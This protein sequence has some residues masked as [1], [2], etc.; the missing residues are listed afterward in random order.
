MKKFTLI[1]LFLCFSASLL[2]QDI[3]ITK[4]NER[5]EAKV[6]KEYEAVILYS[7]FNTSTDSTYL[8]QKAKINTITYE[9]GKVFSYNDIKPAASNISG[10]NNTSTKPEKRF[11]NVIRLKPFV[12]I[13]SAFLGIFEIDLQ[14]V[15]YVGRKVGIPFE[16]D[17]FTGQNDMGGGF[18]LLTGVEAVPVTHRQ[19]SGLFV[20]GLIGIIYC[21]PVKVSADRYNCVGCFVLKGG[22]GLVLNA[23]VGYQLVTKGGLLF[24]AA[25]GPLY[26][27]LTNK[28]AARISID[29]G[30]AF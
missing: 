22:G 14:Y 17:F 10:N 28:V 21:T 15:R 1:F 2:A 6:L 30:V 26:N 7:L 19:K 20:Q 16:L 27:T 13:Y 23:N 11:K 12:T 25:I 24:N 4:E 9:D 29:F 3:I 8:I 5:I 18:A